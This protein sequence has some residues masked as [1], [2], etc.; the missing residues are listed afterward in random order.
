MGPRHYFMGFTN[1][2]ACSETCS[3]C[4]GT[5]HT[6]KPGGAIKENASKYEFDPLA[7]LGKYY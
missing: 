3:R 4:A 1:F 6:R 2:R 5:A 7:L